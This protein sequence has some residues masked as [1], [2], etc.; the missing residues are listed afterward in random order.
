MNGIK[1]LVSD[2]EHLGFP[3][4]FIGSALAGVGL[5]MVQVHASHD[6]AMT[7]VGTLQSALVADQGGLQ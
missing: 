3:R 5:A 6:T 4:A 2:F 7:M 1:G